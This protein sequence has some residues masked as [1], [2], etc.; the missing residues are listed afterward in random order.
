[1]IEMLKNLRFLNQPKLKTSEYKNH[2]LFTLSLL[3]GHKSLSEAKSSSKLQ[4]IS[5]E[6]HQNSNFSIFGFL[7]RK[8]NF[9]LLKSKLIAFLWK[10]IKFQPSVNFSKSNIHDNPENLRSSGHNLQ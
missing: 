1:M 3:Q 2:K 4:Y 8:F 5:T 10:L 6:H 7:F 9:C